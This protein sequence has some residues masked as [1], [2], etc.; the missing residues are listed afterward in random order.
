VRVEHLPALALHGACLSRG[1]S[2]AKE[3]IGGYGPDAMEDLDKRR[4]E[5]SRRSEQ[6]DGFSE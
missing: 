3:M 2:K 1:F 6:R 5:L 4:S